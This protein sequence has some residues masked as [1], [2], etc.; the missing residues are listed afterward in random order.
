MLPPRLRWSTDDASNAFTKAN[1][2]LKPVA[3]SSQGNEVWRKFVGSSTQGKLMK[4]LPL[5]RAPGHAL[6]IHVDAR[7]LL[8]GNSS[9]GLSVVELTKP[10]L[11]VHWSLHAERL[12]H[13]TM[14][15]T[16]KKRGNI[17]QGLSTVPVPIKT[18][19]TFLRSATVHWKFPMKIT[20]DQ[21]KTHHRNLQL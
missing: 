13:H 14:Q 20:C 8:P 1:L 10:L 7:L 18:T 21:T 15:P 3:S 17:C 16:R 9:G 2:F 12:L 5:R 11:L 6:C 19:L 4:F